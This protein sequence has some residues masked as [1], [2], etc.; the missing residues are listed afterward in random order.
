[1]EFLKNVKFGQD[2]TSY[3]YE[4]SAC[5]HHVE[6][7]VYHNLLEYNPSYL[8]DVVFIC[9]GT[10]RA[11][12]DCL[13][14][15]VGTRLELY[16]TSLPV[17]GT[18]AK[19]THAANLLDVLH[20]VYQRY[21]APLVIAIDASLGN[22]DRIGFINVKKGGLK[23]GTALKKNLPEVGD[24]HISGVVNIGGF[25]D[26]MVLQNTR[27]YVVYRMAEII[28]RAVYLAQLKFDREKN[29]SLLQ[30]DQA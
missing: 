22:T 26:Q 3:H 21:H 29:N 2:R 8:K 13:G 5:T 28:A 30:P 14:P 11:T 1:M 7:L 23:P 4:M 9:I 18:L 19:P 16:N 24:F 15:L 25:M 12:G 20:E 6:E 27:L 17:F 10:D